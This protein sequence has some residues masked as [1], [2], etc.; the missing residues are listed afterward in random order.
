MLQSLFLCN[1]GL[2]A[3]AC[4]L[5]SD[6]LLSDRQAPPLRLLHFYNNMSGDGGAIA[7]AG[8]IERLQGLE[9]VR[10]SATRAGQAGSTSIAKVLS[11]TKSACFSQIKFHWILLW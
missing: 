2:S 6:I 10:C 9:D 11:P 5:V 7:V 3:E 4:Q 8:M 1:N